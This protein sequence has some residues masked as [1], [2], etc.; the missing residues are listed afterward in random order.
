MGWNIEPFH[1][2]DDNIWYIDIECIDGDL[3]KLID[4]YIVHICYGDE[5]FS[6]EKA[7]K[8]IRDYLDTKNEDRKKGA[9]A[10]FLIHVF[11]NSID[12][13]Q[14][15]LYKNLE[16]NSPKKGFDGVYQDDK[17]ELWYVESKSGTNKSYNHKDK[18]EEAY[19]DLKGKFEGTVKNDPWLNALQ[20]AKVVNAEE[21]ILDT[22]RKYSNEFD[23][24]TS[25]NIKEFNIIPC[26]TV[27]KDDVSKIYD[28][29]IIEQDVYKYF[30][31]KNKKGL[32]IIC[33]TQKSIAE[34][35][36]YLNK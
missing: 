36:A 15:C 26:G 11:L 17:A 31:E 25:H 19:R 8:Y 28:A 12:Y 14:E 30:E 6:S 32:G 21:S 20:H 16:E 35:E 4:K 1:H 3:E 9:V 2:G 23:K 18:V 29:E 10:E 13:K 22:F 27:Y 34:F 33:V 24:G 7:K 5:C